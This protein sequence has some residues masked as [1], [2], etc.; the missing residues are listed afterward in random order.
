MVEEPVV[1][2]ADPVD[3]EG[4]T[5]DLSRHHV[6]PAPPPIDDPLVAGPGHAVWARRFGRLTA[7]HGVA[8]LPVM[9]LAALPMHFFVGRVDD[10]IVAAPA[11]AELVGGF[12]LLL[13]PAM[14][15]AY[16]AVS[17]LPPVLCLAGAVGVLI[18]WAAEGVRPRPR[19]V[20]RLVAERLRAL[21]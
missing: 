15:L 3:P 18:P 14:W 21:W 9:L 20:W 11:L 16:L 12:G 4:R 6:F 7:R 1:A 13:L 19:R 10:T 2:A 5:A 8:L 17:A